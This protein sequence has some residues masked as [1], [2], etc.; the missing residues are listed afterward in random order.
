M[1]IAILNES[2]LVSDD[3]VQIMALAVQK[4]LDLHVAPA[5]HG[6]SATVKYYADKSAVPGHAWLVSVL[7]TPDV[8][9]ALG[10]HDN[11]ASGQPMGFVFCQPV[12]DNGG[13]VLYDATNPQNVSV[14]SVLSHEVLEMFADRYASFWGDGPK[15]DSYALELC[16][17]VENNSY[18]I[19]VVYNGKTYQVSLSDFVFPSW[20]DQNATAAKNMPFDYLKTL[21]SPFSMVAGGGGYYIIRSEGTEKQVFA[22][23][24]PFWRKELKKNEFSRTSG[25]SKLK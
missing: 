6:K 11:S 16:D 24:M 15:G 18:E 3:E 13:V 8:A 21:S 20:F 5:W 1:L 25:R 12:L 17:P 4:Q 2:K 10:Y 14:S 19:D 22:E 9:N 7:D 23:G